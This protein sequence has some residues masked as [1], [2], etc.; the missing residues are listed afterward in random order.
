[1]RTPGY[2]GRFLVAGGAPGPHAP[3]RARDRE[4]LNLKILKPALKEHTPQVLLGGP[5]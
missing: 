2:R 4:F 5:W 3:F 1:M